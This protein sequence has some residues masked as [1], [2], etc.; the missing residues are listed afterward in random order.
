MAILDWNED[1]NQILARLGGIGKLTPD[2]AVG[3]PSRRNIIALGASAG[4]ALGLGSISSPALAKTA[5]LRVQA[6]YWYRLNVGEAEITVVS[7]GWQM[8]GDPSNSFLGVPKDEVR[9]ELTDNFM[10][11]S[12]MNIELNSFVV[13]NNDRWFCSTE[14]Q[15]CSDPRAGCLQKASRMPGSSARTSTPLSSRT[16]ISTTSAASSMRAVL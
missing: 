9:K 7:D 15:K 14:H 12:D 10:S 16:V 1:R 8:L 4:I 5:K 2:A 13:N 11:P 3:G 6:P